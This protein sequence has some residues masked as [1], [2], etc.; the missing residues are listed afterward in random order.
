MGWLFRFDE[1]STM[2]RRHLAL[3]ALAGALCLAPASSACSD[4]STLI[5]EPPTG[6]LNGGYEIKL[7]GEGF[8]N[9]TIVFM[10]G[11]RI[12]DVV[13]VNPEMI[14]FKAPAADKEGPVD[15][16][17]SSPTGAHTLYEKV[18]RYERTTGVDVVEA[19]EKSASDDKGTSA[20]KADTA[21][22]DGDGDGEGDAP[23]GDG[24]GDGEGAGEGSG[25][26]KYE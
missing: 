24:E 2:A 12:T 1:H 5:A 22:G 20:P 19:F 25:D 7:R 23:A 14:R 16:K 3:V 9:G 10:D 21:A 4:R 18:F 11:K 15:I 26:T 17:I 13:Y 6:G 8:E